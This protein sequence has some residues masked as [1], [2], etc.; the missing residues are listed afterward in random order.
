MPVRNTG[1]T[2]ADLTETLNGMDG[3]SEL[4]IKIATYEGDHGMQVYSVR[5]HEV[6]DEAGE[7]TDAYVVIN[8]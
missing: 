6:T 2:V 4:P 1:M 7:V 3:S 5:R 8:G